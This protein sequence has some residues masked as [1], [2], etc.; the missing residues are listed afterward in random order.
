M[1]FKNINWLSRRYLKYS[2][3]QPELKCMFVPIWIQHLLHHIASLLDAKTPKWSEKAYAF[4]SLL[5]PYSFY[6]FFKKF[7]RYRHMLNQIVLSAPS[8]GIHLKITAFSF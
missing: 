8:I 6:F 3:A 1:V 4:N 7:T 5:W 2:V